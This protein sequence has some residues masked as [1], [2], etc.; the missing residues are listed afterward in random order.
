MNHT[1]SQTEDSTDHILG[2]GTTPEEREAFRARVNPYSQLVNTRPDRIL[3]NAA[4]ELPVQ[5]ATLISALLKQHREVYCEFGS[6]SG[7]H[8][9]EH[10]CRKP[11]ALFFGIELRFKRAFR[12]IEKAE[13]AKAN[14]LYILRTDASLFPKIFPTAS[15]SGVFMNFP[16]PWSR[17]KWAK[18]RMFRSSV[19]KE[20]ALALKPEAIFSFKTDDMA[21]FE[22][23]LAAVTEVKEFK[24]RQ[25]SRDLHKTEYAENLVKSE[26]ERLFISQNLPIYFFNA[27]KV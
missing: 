19:A 7:G 15:L 5:A 24:I 10:A 16:D 14:N 20:I 1:M 18:N 12:T 8:L 27:Q 17:N 3:I 25:V 26:F 23:A 11:E 22:E 2:S 6:G 13:L 21:S 4:R 9:I